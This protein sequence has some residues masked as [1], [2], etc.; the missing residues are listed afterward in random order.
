MYDAL[1]STT[2][3]ETRV[4]PRT[5]N[6]ELARRA[7]RPGGWSR[8]GWIMRQSGADAAA[9]PGAGRGGF[10]GDARGSRGG[11]SGTLSGALLPT[12]LQGSTGSLAGLPRTLPPLT[13]NSGG[14]LDQEG[15][16]PRPTAGGAGNQG[17]RQS[18]GRSRIPAPP[19]HK[20]ATPSPLGL[21]QQQPLPPLP[22]TAPTPAL[23]QVASADQAPTVAAAAPLPAWPSQSITSQAA[24][25][26]H[27]A[28]SEPPVALQQQ[29]QRSG[30]GPKLIVAGA[31]AHSLTVAKA[32]ALDDV[33]T[34]TVVMP[35]AAALAAVAEAATADATAA[36]AAGDAAATV[37]ALNA[38]VAGAGGKLWAATTMTSTRTS[39]GAGSLFDDIDDDSSMELGSVHAS[40][41]RTVNGAAAQAVAAAAAA[42]AAMGAVDAL[43]EEA[44]GGEAQLQTGGQAAAEGEAAAGGEQQ[45]QAA[46][47]Q[48]AG[49]SAGDGE[50][51]PEME[52]EMEAV[53]S[54]L[55]MAPL[56]YA[57]V[58]SIILRGAKVQT[59]CGRGRDLLQSN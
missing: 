18:P 44:E 27:P 51:L 43:A 52:L 1:Q 45:Q 28:A 20:P 55:L 46:G 8:D 24:T 17:A 48:A 16:P 42:A 33:L 4:S 54:A 59:G 38:E 56:D 39:T 5:L 11:L 41:A 23:R 9:S 3:E 40:F 22:S 26:L 13:R 53:E 2:D 49:S 47:T 58:V 31:Q 19:L 25:P 32:D 50:E 21:T 7:P 35:D 14:G 10:F 37:R 12:Q 36:A 30:S 29:Q 57:A 34:S 6:A 15:R